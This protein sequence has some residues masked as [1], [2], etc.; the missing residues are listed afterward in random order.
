MNKAILSPE[1]QQF[2]EEN[3]H[4]DVNRIALKKSPFADVS[5][6][7]LAEQID[8]KS[9]TE[10][11]LPLWYLTPGIY[12]PPKLS[13]E[14]ASSQVTAEYKS[15]LIK[16]GRL[17]D[18]TG[19]IGVDSYYFSKRADVWHVELN[20]ELSE[21]ARYNARILGADNI[22]FINDDSIRYLQT[23]AEKFDTIYIDP[24][25]RVKTQKVFRLADCE[26]DVVSNL[27]L[28]LEKGSRVIIKTAPLLD[29]RAGL[30]ELDHVKEIHVVS[31]KNDCK[32]LLWILEKDFS[33][34][35]Q[36]IC[37]TL[38]EERQEFRFTLSEERDFK[39]GT[40]AEPSGYIYEP[41][42]AL[43]K[44]GCFKLLT[45]A[46]TLDKMHPNTHLYTSKDL[47]DDF[48]GRKFQ[49]LEKWEY[50]AFQASRPLIKAN[51]ICRNFPLSPEEVKKKNKLKD[52]GDDFLLFTTAP[53][54]NLTVLH[55][56]KV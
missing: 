27:S 14:Q 31:V 2:L 1:V 25:R 9:R 40:Y 20:G 24:S 6:R 18:L 36:I 30:K 46:Y 12:F 17:A 38:N 15:S 16:G 22:T 33:G 5:S 28:L 29:L 8:S 56:K 10:K 53:K 34:E 32:E 54:D 37:S 55:C 51:V 45:K 3:L 52:G 49:L 43:L 13:I 50:K 42:V 47:K 48:M 21:I 44:A 11:K 4:T 19:G 41:D 35:P 26:P 23:S 7:E 39:I